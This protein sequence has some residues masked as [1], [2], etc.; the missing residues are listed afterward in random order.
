M[1]IDGRYWVKGGKDFVFFFKELI[2]LGR[3]IGICK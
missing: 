2:Y 1:S 3:N